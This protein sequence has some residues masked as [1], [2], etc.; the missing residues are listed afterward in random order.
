MPHESRKSGYVPASRNNLFK[1][2][3]SITVYWELQTKHSWTHKTI[4]F[5]PL[6]HD[7]KS[8]KPF[9]VSLRQTLMPFQSYSSVGV[10]KRL[11][12]EWL[13][14]L[15]RKSTSQFATCVKEWSERFQLLLVKQD[16]YGTLFIV[17]FN[18]NV[19]GG[20]RCRHLFCPT[21]QLFKSSLHWQN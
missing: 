10:G 4:I 17:D 16:V 12:Q 14:N 3:I 8:K 7:M 15:W 11:S 13:Q 5:T 1:R 21:F 6:L 18:R 20:E 9:L 2:I 19:T